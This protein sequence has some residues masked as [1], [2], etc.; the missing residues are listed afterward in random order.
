MLKGHERKNADNQKLI[1]EFIRSAKPCVELEFDSTQRSAGRAASLRISVARMRSD[2]IRVLQR[3][4]KV[5]LI[6]TCL[7]GCLYAGH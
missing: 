6:N 5:Y 3:K 2:H 1:S 7:I 4:G